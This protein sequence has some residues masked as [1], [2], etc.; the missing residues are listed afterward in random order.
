[1]SIFET[2]GLSPSLKE[3]EKIKTQ[4]QSEQLLRGYLEEYNDI[5]DFRNHRKF[6]KLGNRK[7]VYRFTVKLITLDFL[8]KVAKDKRVKNIMFSPSTP[9][10]GAGIDSI[11][12]RYKIYIEYD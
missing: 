4:E 8:E 5:I 1:M 2:L 9:P 12:M 6:K 3:E 11:S 10:P 7:N